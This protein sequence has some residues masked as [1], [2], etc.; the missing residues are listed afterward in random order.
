MTSFDGFLLKVWYGA[1]V[2]VIFSLAIGFGTLPSLSSSSYF[3]RN[4]IRYLKFFL[5]DELMATKTFF[6][7][8]MAF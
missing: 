4:T 2:Q 1:M 3:S 6:N 7:L 8:E 5:I